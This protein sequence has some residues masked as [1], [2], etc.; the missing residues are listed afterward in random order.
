[1]KKKIHYKAL[2]T[3]LSTDE[4]GLVA[5]LSSGFRCSVRFA[6]QNMDFIGIQNFTDTELV[7]PGD[8]ANADFSLIDADTFIKDLYE[9]MD[10]ELFTNSDKI[11]SGI[12]TEVYVS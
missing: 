9:G 1:M 3:Y 8:K 12:I 4:S 11:G 10:F 6:F 7:F 5:P 2:V